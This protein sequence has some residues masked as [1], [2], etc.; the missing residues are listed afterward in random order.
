LARIALRRGCGPMEWTVLDWNPNS[1]RFYERLGAKL[2]EGW[3]R[4]ALNSTE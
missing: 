1:I 2:R 4:A 3:I